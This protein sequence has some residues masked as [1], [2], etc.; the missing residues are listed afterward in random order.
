MEDVDIAC[1]DDTGSCS[2]S[3]LF[4]HSQLLSE[5]EGRPLVTTVD[6]QRPLGIV[7]RMNQVVTTWVIAPITV[8]PVARVKKR[9]K[10]WH[11]YGTICLMTD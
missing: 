10:H 3:K 5:S 11:D 7:A 8:R 9:Y 6:L 1:V 4:S 2:T